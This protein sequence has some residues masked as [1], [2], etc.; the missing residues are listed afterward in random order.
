MGIT[1]TIPPASEPVTLAEALAHLRLDTSNVTAAP[2]APTVALAS[3]AAP[4]NV[5][6]GAHRWRLTFVTADGETDA[7]TVSSAVTVVDKTVNGQVSLTAIPLGGSGVTSRKL[8]R[9]AAAGT[10]Y[11]LLATIA[12]N[13][14]TTYTD[15]IA[16]ASLGAGAPST[17][18]TADPQVSAIISAARQWTEDYTNRALITQTWRLTLDDFPRCLGYAW[19]GYAPGQYHL[20]PWR[21]LQVIRLPW[22]NLLTVTSITYVDGNGATQTLD[23]SAYVVDTSSLPGRVYPAYGTSWPANRCQPNAVTITYTAGYGSASSVPTA[24]KQAMLLMISD[25]YRERESQ[26]I[27]ARA[28]VVANPTVD[29]LLASAIYRDVA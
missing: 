14:T 18:S 29:R 10:V 21:D 26:I 16:D 7:G 19:N 20:R 1:R 3:P 28:V 27:G 24:V 15:N 25:L 6:N 23:S 8:Y 4:G 13:T 22:P 2:T 17:N 12:D 11:L 9:T 5:D